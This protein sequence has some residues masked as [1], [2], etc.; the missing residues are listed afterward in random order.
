MS[1]YL[2]LNPPIPPTARIVP[3]L[4]FGADCLHFLSISMDKTCPV[5]N[6]FEYCDAC[7]DC[8]VYEDVDDYFENRLIFAQYYLMEKKLWEDAARV[9]Q[10][11][12]DDPIGIRFMLYNAYCVERA[13]V[14][15]NEVA[16]HL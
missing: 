16:E 9:L 14:L 4:R 7:V 12:L 10:S 13:Q 1:V 11:I 8:P 2:K 6:E 5:V 15:L 3:W